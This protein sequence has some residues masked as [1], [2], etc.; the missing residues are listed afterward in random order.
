MKIGRLRKKARNRGFP[1]PRWTPEYQRP[2]RTRR[3]HA[4]ERPIG[5]EQMILADD[6]VEL[7]RSQFVGERT[8]RIFIEACRGKQIWAACFGAR[9]H[10]LNTAEIFCPPRR[11]TMR[12]LRLG[13]LVNRSR[14]RVLPIRSPL[15]S[16][17]TSPR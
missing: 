3:Q 7:L 2:Q 8:R 15:T 12:Q 10:P 14:S 11:M 17:I 16:S 6:F 13:V 5:P 1:G 4:R 9:D